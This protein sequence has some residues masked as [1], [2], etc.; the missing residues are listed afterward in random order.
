MATSVRALA[1]LHVIRAVEPRPRRRL[2]LTYD[3]GSVVSVDLAPLI[4]RGG[5]F[6]PL[7]DWDLFRQVCPGP[8]GRSLC[9]PGDIDLCADALRMQATADERA[10]GG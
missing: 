8:R 3:D 4:Q 5:V 7:A 9:W 6:A 1:R 10:T 2:A